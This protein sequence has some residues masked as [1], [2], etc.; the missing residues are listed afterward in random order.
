MKV[1]KGLILL[2][3]D[4]TQ[5]IQTNLSIN[6]E[7]SNLPPLLVRLEIQQIGTNMGNISTLPT[8][9]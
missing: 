7:F 6:E 4:R 3:L 9:S 5:S 1:M 8:V 2:V